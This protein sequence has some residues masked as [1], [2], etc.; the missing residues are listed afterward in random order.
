MY[1]GVELSVFVRKTLVKVA[2]LLQ[3]VFN[4]TGLEDD[5]TQLELFQTFIRAN[6]PKFHTAVLCITVF[7]S[8]YNT[9]GN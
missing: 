3:N 2:K 4:E 6:I 5:T 1:T 9:F 7:I 8:I